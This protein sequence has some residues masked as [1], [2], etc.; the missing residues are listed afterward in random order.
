MPVIHTLHPVS[1]VNPPQLRMTAGPAFALTD[2]EMQSGDIQSNLDWPQALW[3]FVFQYKKST[4]DFRS[5]MSFFLA[6]RAGAYGFWLKDPTDFADDGLGKV[7]LIGGVYRLVKEYPDPYSPYRR[8]ITR[9]M[10]GTV[11]F[12]GVSGSPSVNFTTGVVSGATSEGTA[13]FQY[14]VP[15]KFVTNLCRPEFSPGAGLGADIAEWVQ[16]EMRELR[17]YVVATSP[18]AF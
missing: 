13:K 3:S 2:T 1:L 6:R 17:S 7:R 14:E 16:I 11:T 5:V 8:F 10:P 4:T 12:S 15:V 9:P 18:P